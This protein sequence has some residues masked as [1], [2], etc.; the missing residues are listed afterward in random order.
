M[1]NIFAMS[2]E[3]QALLIQSVSTFGQQLHL[4]PSVLWSKVEN[5]QPSSTQRSQSQPLPVRRTTQPRTD[6]AQLASSAG[7]KGSS[8]PQFYHDAE[9]CGHHITESQQYFDAVSAGCTSGSSCTASDCSFDDGIRRMRGASAHL[10]TPSRE[11]AISITDLQAMVL[12]EKQRRRIAESALS[13]LQHEHEQM[14][15]C[16]ASLEAAHRDEAAALRREA[17]ANRRAAESVTA[18]ARRGASDAVPTVSH[19]CQAQALVARM[20]ADITSRA[21][22]RDESETAYRTELK[23]LRQHNALLQQRVD[24]LSR[25]SI[26]V[27]A[28]AKQSAVAEQQWPQLTTRNA[29]LAICCSSFGFA[30]AVLLASRLH[31]A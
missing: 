28:A 9:A 14:T 27:D 11:E 26:A 10:L 15:A 30:G 13:D 19:T 31:R 23:L 8:P 16:I 1:A 6:E 29:A 20:V 4:P 2:A 17:A 3:A 24:Q 25:M 21:V 5:A 22:A 12:D 7:C 18:A